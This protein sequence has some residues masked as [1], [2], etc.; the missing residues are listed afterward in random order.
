MLQVAAAAALATVL[1]TAC[2]ATPTPP[3]TPPVLPDDMHWIRAAHDPLQWRKQGFIELTTVVRPP[4][5]ED[6]GVHIV[7][8]M[9][10]PAGSQLGLSS[11]DPAIAS[12]IPS[13]LQL[14]VGAQLARIEYAGTAHA[15]DA[16]ADA[17]WRVLDVRQFDMRS[18]GMDCTVLRPDGTGALVG[19]RWPC[20]VSNDARAANLL[21]TFV[22]EQRFA[23]PRSSAGRERAAN[24]VAQI[25]GCIACHQPNRAE[26]RRPS[27]LVQRGTDAAGLFSL[28]SVFRNEDPSEHYRPVDNNLNDPQMTRTCPASEVDQTGVAC[29]DG[30]RPRLRLDVAN[31][32]ARG[33]P[34]VLALC[35]TRLR[36]ATLVAPSEQA[37]LQA[38]VDECTRLQNVH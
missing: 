15:P 21:A 14:P 13:S 24:H 17:T 23:A 26:D 9:G 12:S 28:R 35:A 7:V 25:N 31:G 32:L 3:T 27:A 2:R 1:V 6:T 29:R 18:D 22:R 20:S 16:P 5:S 38:M 30:L 10:I 19:L 37:P 8:V 33:A 11:T 36:L 34:H 4:T